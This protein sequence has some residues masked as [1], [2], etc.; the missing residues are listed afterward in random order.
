[1]PGNPHEGHFKSH[2]K[3]EPTLK[4]H[5]GEGEWFE[6]HP[7][8]NDFKHYRF[9]DGPHEDDKVRRDI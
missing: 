9:K 7:Q 1:M 6:K 5:H 3:H 8:A 4:K 2:E